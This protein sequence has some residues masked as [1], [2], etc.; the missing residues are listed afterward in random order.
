MALFT[1]IEHAYQGARAT[2]LH[3]NDN[4]L[5]YWGQVHEGEIALLDV[6][7][8]N[9]TTTHHGFVP[10]LPNNA[11]LFFNGIGTYTQVTE[12]GILL[13]DVTTDD[14]STARHGFVPKLPNDVNLFFTGVGTYTQVT[15]AGILLADVTTDDV[16]TTK[17]GF[18]P[19]LNNDATT[20]LNG[21]GAYTAAVIESTGTFT[22]TATGMTTT[23]TGTA[24]WVKQGS[25]VNLYFPTLSG[26]SNA[27]SFTLTGLP[28]GIQPTREAYGAT[29]VVDNGT[30][31]TGYCHLQAGS[32]TIEMLVRSGS[33]VWTNSGTKTVGATY[34][35]YNLA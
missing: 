7:T 8:G 13:A 35:S 23:V 26:T 12:A 17:H 19:K 34:L 16:S 2:V 20:F 18:A 5:L 3:G 29:V 22:I 28:A 24:R 10:K 6:T 1:D 15:E 14:V 21:Q 30:G 25:V 31:D 11:N 4:G 33:N 9:V 27:T 32:G